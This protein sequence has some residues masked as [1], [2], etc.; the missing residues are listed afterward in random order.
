MNFKCIADKCTHSCCIGWEIDVDDYTYEM[1]ENIGSDFGDKIMSCIHTDDEGNHNFILGENDR[2]PF[3]N[4]KGLCDIILELGEDYLSDICRE[5][6]RFYVKSEDV[7]E[8]CKGIF[9]R[10][11]DG[12]YKGY[13]LCCEEACRII[14]QDNRDVSCEIASLCDKYRKYPDFSSK[15]KIIKFAKTLL[16]L[17]QLGNVWSSWLEKLIE[18]LCGQ[19]DNLVNRIY[20]NKED[21]GT[22]IIPEEYEKPFENLMEY[23]M[24]RFNNERFASLMWQFVRIMYVCREEMSLDALADICR[25]YSCQIEYSDENVE[26]ISNADI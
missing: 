22:C 20:Q 26:K 13:G 8:G 2:C 11:E 4:D 12:Y 10:D 24:F 21:G 7:C 23:L 3:L 1:Y 25:E 17:E 5:H 18:E 6:P 16:L 14:L 19:S 15:D 9:E